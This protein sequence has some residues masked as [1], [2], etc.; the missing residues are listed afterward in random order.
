MEQVYLS[1]KESLV[2]EA[3]G[4]DV[5]NVVKTNENILN[6]TIRLLYILPIQY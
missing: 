4:D 6:R 2:N 3:A 5:D 1:S